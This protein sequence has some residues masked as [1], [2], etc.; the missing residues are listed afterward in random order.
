VTEITD[1]LADIRGRV[2]SAL[3]RA[4][5]KHD[6][7][8]IVAVS[9]QQSTDRIAAACRAGQIH[10]GESYVQEALP[11]MDALR[12]LPIVWHYIGPVQGNKTRQIAERFQWVHSVDRAKIAERLSAQRPYHAPPLNV[13]LQVNL[14]A[15]P[16]KAGARRHEAGELAARIRALP[17]LALRGL[18]GIPPAHASREETTRFF[19]D[20]RE[21]KLELAA[22]GIDTDTLSMGM[23]GDF[24]TAILCGSTCVRIGT[25]IF[26]PRGTATV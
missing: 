21:L 16:Q 15:E 19:E 18:M 2:A 14:A 13:L 8:M 22:T 20:L 26:G 1:H 7:V 11:K 12:D 3:D 9:K 4:G 17:K 24:E 25:A 10:F 23:S 5:R 6:D